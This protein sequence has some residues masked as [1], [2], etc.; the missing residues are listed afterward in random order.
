MNDQAVGAPIYAPATSSAVPSDGLS[1]ESYVKS[2]IS[3]V[4][5][6]QTAKIFAAFSFVA[7]IPF[8]VLSAVEVIAL[9]GPRPPFFGSFVVLL[10]VLYAA[11]SFVAVAI[12]AWV[13][14]V[15]AKRIGGIEFTSTVVSSDA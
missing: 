11:S 2:Q 10:P 7:S 9:P 8:L 14:N 5:V 13:Y 6:V 1:L 4:S 3:H 15:L 12:A